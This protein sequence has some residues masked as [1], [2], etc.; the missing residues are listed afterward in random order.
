MSPKPVKRGRWIRRILAITAPAMLV[1]LAYAAPPASAAT[2]VTVHGTVRCT[3]GAKVVGVW[4]NSSAGGSTWAN[5][6]PYPGTAS[7]AIIRKTISTNFPTQ[8]RLDVGCGGTPAS[9]AS[10]NKTTLLRMSSG[11]SNPMNAFCNGAGTCTWG[12]KENNTPA[13]GSTNQFASRQNCW[14][15][16][17]AAERWKTM[18]GRYPNWNGNANRWDDNAAATGWTVSN[19]ASPR[20]LFV[21]NAGTLGHV[22]YV[23]DVRISSGKVQI[24]IDDRNSNGSCRDEGRPPYDRIKEWI[25]VTSTMKFIVPPPVGAI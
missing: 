24:L 11:S 19:Y 1:S 21:D 10:N 7:V 4:I 16:Y 6:T 15:T 20:S 17:L 5:W 22:G 18:T 3:N 12:K 25:N 9:W 13:A 23:R 14:C 8:L 2:S